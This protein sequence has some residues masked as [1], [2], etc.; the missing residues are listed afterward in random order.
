MSQMIIGLC[1]FFATMGANGFYFGQKLFY[2]LQGADLN[3]QFK[4]VFPNGKLAD[5][6]SEKAKQSA[7]LAQVM[8]TPSEH[9]LAQPTSPTHLLN[10]FN[11]HTLSIHHSTDLLNP[12]S[13]PHFQ[14][15]LSPQEQQDAENASDAILKKIKPD[16]KAAFLSSD[17]PADCDVLFCNERIALWTFFRQELEKR[18]EQQKFNSESGESSTSHHTTPLHSHSLHFTPPFFKK[19]LSDT[20]PTIPHHTTPH[21]L[22]PFSS[23]P[24][25]VVSIHIGGSGVHD[26]SWADKFIGKVS[27]AARSK[28]VASQE[29][30]KDASEHVSEVIAKMGGRR[31][32][33]QA[34]SHMSGHENHSLHVIDEVGGKDKGKGQHV[35]GSGM[36][37]GMMTQ[38]VSRTSIVSHPSRGTLDQRR[39]SEVNAEDFTAE[40]TAKIKQS[41][42]FAKP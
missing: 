7:T 42:S 5:S 18:F 16:V 20:P 34:S 32:E 4:I 13:H 11:Q 19:T 10:P 28:S 1:F 12:P 27:R 35:A 2:L 9:T 6:A 30:E 23:P 31:R 38:P 36:M 3:A 24:C 8:N 41:S 17:V 14:P 37:S 33:S 21:L 29:K 25:I 22:M 26:G 15:T 39:E 40:L